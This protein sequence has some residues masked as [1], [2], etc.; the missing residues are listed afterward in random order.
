MKYWWVDRK[1]ESETWESLLTTANND[2]VSVLILWYTGV[3]PGGTYIWMLPHTLEK[4][5]KAYLLKFNFIDRKELTK[6]GQNGHGLK[7]VWIKYKEN[8]NTTTTKPEINIAFEEI[9]NDLSTIETKIRYTGFIHLSS[10]WLLYF[11]I[12]L[13]S[14]L[15]YLI[16]W[17]NKYRTTFY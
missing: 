17:K 7:D 2:F 8:S 1:I 4:Y 16:I 9:I 12:V 11:Y 14:F 13:C 6:F 10:D 3:A 15:R 5:L